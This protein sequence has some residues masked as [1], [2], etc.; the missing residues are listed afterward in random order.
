MLDEQELGD[1]I[2][3]RFTR[4]LF[5]LETLDLYDVASNDDEYQR[6]LSGEVKP[7]P[8]RK[9]AY[10]AILIGGASPQ[11]NRGLTRSTGLS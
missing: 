10:S 8:E 2:D 9:E 11:L 5:R 4:V 3:S 6:Y 1:Y 7:N